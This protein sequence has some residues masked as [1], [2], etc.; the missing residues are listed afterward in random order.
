MV[1]IHGFVKLKNLVYINININ[2]F[3]GL[4]LCNTP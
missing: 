3:K 4:L 2:E 1:G